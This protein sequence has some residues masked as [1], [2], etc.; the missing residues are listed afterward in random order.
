MKGDGKLIDYLN[1]ILKNELTS[2]NQY[3]VHAR[4]F[5]NWG[6]HTSRRSARFANTWTR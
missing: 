2:I 6:L 1:K 4:M 5:K 3:F